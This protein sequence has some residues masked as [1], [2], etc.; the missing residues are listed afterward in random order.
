[1]ND[2]R[3]GLMTIFKYCAFILLS[4]SSV[5]WS[6]PSF[7]RQG[8][9]SGGGG[10][11]INPQQ[12]TYVLATEDAEHL[13]KASV[14]YTQIFFSKAQKQYA[15]QS[16]PI[17]IIPIYEKIFADE[18]S[19][20]KVLTEVHP[21][22]RDSGPCYDFSQKPVDASVV[23]H[24]PNHF[25]VSSYSVARKVEAEQIPVQA[26]ALMAH[27]YSEIMGLNEDEAVV[28]QKQALKFLQ[29]ESLPPLEV[30]PC[31]DDK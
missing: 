25:C 7:L 20:N 22:V 31:E 8:G 29:S 10:N 16:A 21:K 24:E 15:D 18:S 13:V 17:E 14:L 23:S 26:A 4:G 12:P 28:I 6:L 5:C 27:E 2:L 1:M 30:Q 9:V 3:G 11:I 19:L